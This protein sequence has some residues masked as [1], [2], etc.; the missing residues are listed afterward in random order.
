MLPAMSTVAFGLVVALLSVKEISCL[1]SQGSCHPTK[2][3]CSVSE[4]EDARF[5]YDE[6]TC[7]GNHL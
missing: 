6:D 5:T 4:I 2:P 1:G 7:H 3:N